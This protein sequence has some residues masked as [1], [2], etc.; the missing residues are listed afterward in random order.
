MKTPFEDEVLPG[1]LENLKAR[2]TK[3]PPGESA[4]PPTLCV[5]HGDAST[6]MCSGQISESKDT[7]SASYGTM[8]KTGH[9]LGNY[10][11]Q[12]EAQPRSEGISS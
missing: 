3:G 8:E 10:L 2:N 7:L 4:G 5:E 1:Q 6:S 12:G 9:L 11:M